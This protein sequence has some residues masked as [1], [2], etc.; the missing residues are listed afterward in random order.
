MKFTVDRKTWYRG[1]GPSG[2]ALLREDGCRCC[3]G[4]VGQQCGV[5]DE[6]LLNVRSVEYLKLGDQQ[7]AKFPEWMW[8]FVGHSYAGIEQAYHINDDRFMNDEERETQ[9]KTIFANNGD[10]IEF[11]N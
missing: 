10:E 9:L 5:P 11:V 1:N 3:I 7:K 4:F 8:E 6:A 2:S